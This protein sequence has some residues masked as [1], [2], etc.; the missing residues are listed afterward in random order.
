M[1]I[2]GCVLAVIL[3]VVLLSVLGPARQETQ[4]SQRRRMGGIIAAARTSYS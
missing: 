1:L 4:T 2:F 3:V